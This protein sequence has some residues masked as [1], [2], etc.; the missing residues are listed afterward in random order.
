MPTQPLVDLES[1]F[2]AGVHVGH[3]TSR[4]HPRMAPY[5]HSIRGGRYLIDLAQT[6]AQ[7]EIASS[8]ITGTVA[9]GKSLMFIGTKR[10]AKTI[11]KAA[12][13]AVSMPY[14]VE[15]WMGGF[16]TNHQT[17]NI[18][19]KR[20]KDL[21]SRMASGELANKYSKLE[22]QK[23][24]KRIDGLNLVYGGIKA[25]SGLPGAV[26]IVD[27]FGDAIAVAEA[28]KLKIPIIGLIDTN[29][30]PWLATYPIVANDDAIKS[31]QILTDA[32]QA[33]VARGLSQRATTSPQPAAG[34]ATGEPDPKAPPAPVTGVLG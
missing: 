20:L 18:Q 7:L 11:V 5:I 8:A 22:V 23:I 15:R 24:Q 21:E 25:M 6:Q 3:T 16:L 31:L 2:D 33:A 34:P 27:M 9:S 10:Q 28:N 32:I 19:V 13:E 14:V 12:A 26:F 30:D 1:L 4:W 17:I 29:I